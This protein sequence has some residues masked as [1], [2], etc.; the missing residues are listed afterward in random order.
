MDSNLSVYIN[1]KHAH[2]LRQTIEYNFVSK[3]IKEQLSDFS[4]SV[5]KLNSMEESVRRF[6]VYCAQ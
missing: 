4:T 5:S 2:V 3:N 1:V 6:S